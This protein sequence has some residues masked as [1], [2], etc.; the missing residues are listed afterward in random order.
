MKK[1]GLVFCLL[2]A[3]GSLIMT[4]AISQ[5][6]KPE[7][8]IWKKVQQLLNRGQVQAACQTA[9]KLRKYK[10]TPTYDKAE[11]ALQKRGISLGDPLGSY[12]LMRIIDLQN[13]LEDNRAK[14]GVFPH[15][16][17]ARNSRMAGSSPSGWRSSPA[18]ASPICCARPAGTAS[19]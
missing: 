1:T 4:P 5:A 10:D 17:H 13:H 11:I 3:L 8:L 14:T 2:V 6:A 9:E 18:R 16:A 7:V 19:G 12:T 15:R